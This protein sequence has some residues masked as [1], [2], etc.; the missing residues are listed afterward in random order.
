MESAWQQRLGLLACEWGRLRDYSGGVAVFGADCCR[1]GIIDSESI[2]E[3]AE[4]VRMSS[5][6]FLEYDRASSDIYAG[7]V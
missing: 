4:C 3:S 1:A 6:G 2:S 5:M 7:I